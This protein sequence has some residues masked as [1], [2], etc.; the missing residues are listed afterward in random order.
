MLHLALI[1]K[2]LG[3]LIWSID[4]G[5]RKSHVRF[6]ERSVLCVVNQVGALERGMWEGEEIRWWWA[7]RSSHIFAGS[8]IGEMGFFYGWV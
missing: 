8:W 5:G 1:S 6:W 4:S 3:R 7:S 2:N